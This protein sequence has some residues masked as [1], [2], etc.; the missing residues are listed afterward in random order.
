M[1]ALPKEIEKEKE[2]EPEGEVKDF[3]IEFTGKFK[4]EMFYGK[5]I[6]LFNNAHNFDQVWYMRHTLDFNLH[7]QYGQKTYGCNVVETKFAVRDKA[8]WGNPRTIAAIVGIAK[9]PGLL[10]H[11]NLQKST[12][13][14]SASGSDYLTKR[15]NDKLGLK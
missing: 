11:D 2:L 14:H 4:P 7:T 9:M 6:S 8:V 13:T 12:V 1:P 3:N 15:R 5:N 10:L